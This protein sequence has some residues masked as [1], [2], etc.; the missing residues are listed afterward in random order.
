MSK[1]WGD[2]EK[3]LLE[4]LKAAIVA[5]PVLARPD[6]KRRFYLKTD[7]SCEGMGAVLLQAEDTPEARAHE[8]REIDGERCAFDQ[9]IGGLRLRPIAFISQR[10]KEGME[11]SMH[12]YVGEA[13]TL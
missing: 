4:R 3:V 5:G 2:E 8:Q 11:K 10:T 12:S 9:A 6:P 7:W 13:A 1:L